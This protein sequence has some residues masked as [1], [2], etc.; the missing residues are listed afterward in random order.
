[1]IA[2]KNSPSRLPFNTRISL[3]GSTARGRSN[4]V[5]SQ[6]AAARRNG[7]IPLARG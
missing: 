1:V 7:S 5:F 3:S 4:R 2:A 6:L